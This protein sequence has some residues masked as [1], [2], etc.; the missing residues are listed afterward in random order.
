M[1]KLTQKDD[2]GNWGLKGVHWYDL[3]PGG[4]ITKEIYEKLYAALW[5]LMEY[6]ETGFSP[7]QIR[8]M[9][10]L[11]GEKCAELA[12]EKQKHRWIPVEERLPDISRCRAT[13]KYEMEAG[14]PVY[15][16][17]DADFEKCQNGHKFK[18]TWR[19]DIT[20]GVIA[21][22]TLPDPYR[23]EKL[24]EVGRPAADR[25]DQDTLPEPA[26]E[27]LMQRFTKVM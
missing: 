26:K 1:R 8:E 3:C 10:D 22:M 9:C 19:N 18:D 25:A 24:N 2:Q 16:V 21:W 12:E 6:E 27:H 5:K 15:E 7:D 11:Y 13:V 20:D 4:T 14:E 23:P 17:I